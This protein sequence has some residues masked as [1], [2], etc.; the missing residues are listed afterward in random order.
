MSRNSTGSASNPV[1]SIP[2]VSPTALPTTTPVSIEIPSQDADQAD[3][4]DLIEADSDSDDDVESN[5]VHERA[6]RQASEVLLREIG[7]VVSKTKDGI[8]AAWT[9]TNSTLATCKSKRSNV[10]DE[11]KREEAT[12]I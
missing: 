1:P 5:D 10:D 12:V 4:E 2:A 11:W 9:V 8:T 6:R 3:E 7:K